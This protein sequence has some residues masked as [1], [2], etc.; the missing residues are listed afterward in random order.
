MQPHQHA[1]QQAVL[2][3]VAGLTAQRLKQLQGIAAT[4]F[5]QRVED[6]GMQRRQLGATQHAL[7][8]HG[9]WHT[10]GSPTVLK[11]L[12]QRLQH[13]GRHRFQRRHQRIAFIGVGLGVEHEL[14]QRL[15]DQGQQIIG[16]HHLAQALAVR[17]IGGEQH[18]QRAGS[19]MTLAPRI[20]HRIDQH[21]AVATNADDM[22]QA[23][24]Q[25]AVG[26]AQATADDAIDQQPPQIRRADAIQPLL[27]LGAT[28]RGMGEQLIEN[29]ARVRRWI[30]GSA[31]H[32]AVL[33]T[34]P[35]QAYSAFARPRKEAGTRWPTPTCRRRPGES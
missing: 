16:R 21:L 32:L 6:L 4:F 13:L 18:R 10:A 3:R 1:L 22:K 20:G 31:R 24:N 14:R 35:P 2:R 8:G 7:I 11:L 28:D 25:I 27:Q 30:G 19:D 9:R 12:K 34:E 17:R 33:I 26:L 5:G 15:G 29:R 23:D